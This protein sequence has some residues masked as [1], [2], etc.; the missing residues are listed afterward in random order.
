MHWYLRFLMKSVES[1]LRYPSS[2]KAVQTSAA[3]REL[4]EPKWT[5]LTSFAQCFHYHN[6]YIENLFPPSQLESSLHC[7]GWFN[8]NITTAEEVWHFRFQAHFSGAH[9][10]SWKFF[11]TLEKDASSQKLMY[12]KM[13]GDQV[14]LCETYNTP[15]TKKFG[16]VQLKTSSGS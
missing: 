10:S 5:K 15:S 13:V 3:Y 8:D 11:S 7:S 14:S 6:A 1:K 9:P 2:W 4:A 12:L 16:A